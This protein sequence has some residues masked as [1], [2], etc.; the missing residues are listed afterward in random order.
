MKNIIIALSVF[1]L[2]IVSTPKAEAALV[3][4]TICREGQ[5]QTVSGIQALILIAQKKATYGACPVVVTPVATSTPVKK[6][7]RYNNLV[8]LGILKTVI[9]TSTTTVG[10]ENS[11]YKT[12]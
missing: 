10:S 11:T 8:R 3:N 12:N 4:V 1:A 9:T 2:F 5:T 7:G 6:G